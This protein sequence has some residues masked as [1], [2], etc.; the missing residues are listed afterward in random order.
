LSRRVNARS[1]PKGTGWNVRY[2]KLFEF[3][4]RSGRPAVGGRL[5][6]DVPSK[7]QRL[8]PTVASVKF[9]LPSSVVGI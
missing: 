8:L 1:I 7:N 5:F 9:I 3:V 4:F 2:V 6:L